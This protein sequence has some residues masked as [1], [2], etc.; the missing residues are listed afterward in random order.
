VLRKGKGGGRIIGMA[1]GMD[2][3]IAAGAC[4][5]RRGRPK[6]KPDEE[7]RVR[8]VERAGKLFRDK[9][10]GPTTT[11]DLA[12][13]CEVSKRTL[14]RLFGSK[15][16]LFAA[17]VAAYRFE[18]LALPGDYDD[19]PLEEALGRIFKIDIDDETDRSRL[20]F[21]KVIIVE[22]SHSSDLRQVLRT[23]GGDKARAH[24]AAWLD[25]Q[26][27][28]GR[29][30]VRDVENAAQ[31]LIDMLFGSAISRMFSEFNWPG[32]ARRREYAHHCIALFLNGV[33]PR[34]AVSDR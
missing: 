20:A 32:S 34:A 8:I 2:K 12:A 25:H 27:K 9:G 24:L 21:L 33:L 17:V 19:L 6:V 13:F 4:A 31:I 10:Y 5:G 16:S 18:M 26:R 7:Q 29:I 11:D 15:L 30:E 3:E 14:Y 1:R 22:A 28:L 23:Y